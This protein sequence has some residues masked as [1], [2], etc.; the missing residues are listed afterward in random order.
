MPLSNMFYCKREGLHKFSVL[1][2][3]L[4]FCLTQFSLGDYAGE[5]AN[6]SQTNFNRV[7]FTTDEY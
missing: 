3:I 1:I 6:L 7:N 2:E 4:S 5:Y